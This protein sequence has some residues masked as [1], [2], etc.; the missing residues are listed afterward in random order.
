M[1]WLFQRKSSEEVLLIIV[2]IILSG[3]VF[4]MLLNPNKLKITNKEPLIVKNKYSYDI[5]MDTQEEMLVINSKEEK[6]AVTTVKRLG[7]KPVY[8]WTIHEILEGF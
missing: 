7:Q 6:R 5:E 3:L 8:G 2:T 4:V 1:I